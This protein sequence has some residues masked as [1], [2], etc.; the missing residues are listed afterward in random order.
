LTFASGDDISVASPSRSSPATTSV[1]SSSGSSSCYGGGRNAR[2][3]L[4]HGYIFMLSFCLSLLS[5]DVILE[6]AKSQKWQNGKILVRRIL[7]K[8]CL[9][10]PDEEED[11]PWKKKSFEVF[12]PLFA[13]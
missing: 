3:D 9:T 10:S 4:L 11:D 1:S 7:Q 12:Y 13:A 2:R 8:A 6:Q 5:F